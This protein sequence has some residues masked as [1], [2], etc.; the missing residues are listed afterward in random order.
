MSDLLMANDIKGIAAQ[1]EVPSCSEQ[2]T[3]LQGSMRGRN[4]TLPTKTCHPRLY[5]V[6]LIDAKA[7]RIFVTDMGQK[8]STIQQ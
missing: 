2:A 4:R 8:A 3:R 5:I 6:W 7:L 1:G